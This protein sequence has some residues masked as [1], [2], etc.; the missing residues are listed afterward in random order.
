MGPPGAGKGTQ[1]T[2]LA[3][4]MGMVHLSTG[5]LIR[6]EIQ[7]RS[8]LGI[9]VESLVSRGELVGDGLVMALVANRLEGKESKWILFDGIP[10]TV[11][12]AQTLEGI[13]HV[14]LVPLLVVPDEVV[15]ERIDGRREDPVT[16]QIY[17]LVTN[18]PPDEIIDRLVQR[19][20]DASLETV[21]ARLDVYRQETAPVIDW[22]EQLGLLHPIDGTSS[23][24]R[25]T[26]A[27]VVLL[28]E[29]VCS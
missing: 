7:T 22:Y 9:E 3:E 5:D 2:A 20:D 29:R 27:L 8:P 4:R 13:C 18:P 16:G 12:Q 11:G 10:R 15:L 17:H 25:I 6:E 23:P 21:K 14:D 28:E 24:S 1:A 26:D 19:K